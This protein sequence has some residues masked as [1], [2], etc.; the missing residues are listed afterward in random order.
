MLILKLQRE[1]EQQKPKKS[2]SSKPR[3]D[4]RTSDTSSAKESNAQES[5]YVP[6]PGTTNESPEPNQIRRLPVRY[7]SNEKPPKPSSSST[8]PHDSGFSSAQSAYSS[9][10]TPSVSSS[11]LDRFS[12]EEMKAQFAKELK[13]MIQ[14]EVN[15]QKFE[16][17]HLHRI[18]NKERRSI[19]LKQL[20]KQLQEGGSDTVSVSSGVTGSELQFG[21]KLERQL[22]AK[23]DN[24]LKQDRIDTIAKRKE[25]EE[26]ERQQKFEETSKE[27][28]RKMH[29]FQ[30]ARQ[31]DLHRRIET[32]KAKFDSVQVKH[33]LHEE[34][35]LQRNE[36]IVM[37]VVQKSLRAD[38]TVRKRYTDA[39]VK[40]MERVQ[41]TTL[42]AETLQSVHSTY[43]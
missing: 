8:L 30:T 28:Q 25:I 24:M 31:E 3:T 10:V 2:K 11:K 9:I 22:K 39:Q 37:G 34:S 15:K 1:M 16:E 6:Y 13:M 27:T 33:K 41:R 5:D 18:E 21:S 14:Q 43:E 26:L 36:E 38:A 32:S 35:R 29:E 42:Q 4:P 17:T 7:Q 23:H 40:A 12:L 19:H 20:E